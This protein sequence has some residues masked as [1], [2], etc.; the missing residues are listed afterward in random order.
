M[1]LEIKICGLT[2]AEDARIALD[3]GAD[4]LGFVFYPDSPRAV[5][6]PRAAAILAALGRPCRAVG[7]FVNAVP[8]EVA[9]V[10]AACGLHA[11][12]IHG[13]EPADAFAGFPVPVW[14]AVR[15]GTE[16]VRPDPAAW[17]AQRYVV[18]AAVPGRY[19]GTGV[20][21]DWER[22]ARLAAA[23]PVMLAG[24]LTPDNVAGAVRTVRPLGVD[25][26][27][28]VE[29]A[30]GRKDPARLAAFIRGAR[31]PQRPCRKGP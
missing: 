23:Q 30:P 18:D 25:V 17:P 8:D 2:C 21:A 10:A 4:Y 12:Q 31:S 28:G 6:A 19:G 1:T 15:C 24:G 22:A 5:T 26:S 3:A 7:V 27:G 9:R 29:A 16:G 11:V 20:R 13:D 14:R